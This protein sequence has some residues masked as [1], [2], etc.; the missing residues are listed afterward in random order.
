MRSVGDECHYIYDLGDE[1]KHRLKVISVTDLEGGESVEILDGRGACPRKIA[2]AW[3]LQEK[4]EIINCSRK[5]AKNVN[6]TSHWLTGQEIPFK[7]LDYNLDFH[8]YVLRQMVEDPR[9]EKPP[10]YLQ[11]SIE[12]VNGLLTVQ[13]G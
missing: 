9:I 5:A 11:R 6:Y 3:K 1:W 12:A 10:K 8:R 4:C 7:P 2:W 13:E